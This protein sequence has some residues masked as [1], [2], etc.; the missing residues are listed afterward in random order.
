MAPEPTKK[1]HG[2][3]NADI[4]KSVH[5][6]TQ[7]VVHGSRQVPRST[8]AKDMCRIIRATPWT[9]EEL[10]AFY[11]AIVGRF[12]SKTCVRCGKLKAEKLEGSVIDLWGQMSFVCSVCQE[13][14]KAKEI[15]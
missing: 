13:L 3:T 9:S 12:K 15:G 5:D 6:L 8:V 2:L 14:M 7:E 11:N 4:G 10:D 1:I